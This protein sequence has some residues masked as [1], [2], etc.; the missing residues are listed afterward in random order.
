MV[1]S[2]MDM[3]MFIE[4]GTWKREVEVCEWKSRGGDV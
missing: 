2:K 3:A 4:D 1:I